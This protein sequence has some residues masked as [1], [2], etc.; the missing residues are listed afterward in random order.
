MAGENGRANRGQI[1]ALVILLVGM[2]IGGFLVH[3]GHDWAGTLIAG[4]NLLGMA[5]LFIGGGA[6]RVREPDEPRPRGES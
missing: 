1:F 2:L 5:A 6:A 3:A 4:A